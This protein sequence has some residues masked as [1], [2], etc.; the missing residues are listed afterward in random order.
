[1]NVRTSILAGS[2]TGN[3]EIGS[4]EELSK[5]IN[6]SEDNGSEGVTPHD[7]WED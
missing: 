6:L 4:G 7:V 5:E 1:M 2:P 3:D